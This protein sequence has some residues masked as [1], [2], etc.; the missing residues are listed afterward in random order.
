MPIPACLWLKDDVEAGISGSDG[1][2][3]VTPRVSHQ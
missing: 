1:E 2:T 3:S